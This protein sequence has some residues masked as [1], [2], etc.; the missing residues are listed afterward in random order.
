MVGNNSTGNGDQIIKL[1]INPVEWWF[2]LIFCSLQIFIGSI[3]NF[4]VIVT[5]FVSRQLRQRSEDRLILNLAITDFIC[6]T[7]ALPWHIYIYS[8]KQI[9]VNTTSFISNFSI[10]VLVVITGS[11]TIFCIAVDRFVAVV[12]PLRHPNI[13]NT[14]VMTVLS[15]GTAILVT[16]AIYLCFKF[17]QYGISY[18]VCVTS[19][20]LFLAMNATLYAI[21]FYHTLKQG[22]NILNKRRSVGAAKDEFSSHLLLKITLR[23]FLL[24]CLFYITYLPWAIYIIHFLFV[25][26]HD[27]ED[28]GDEMIWIRRVVFLNSF[29]NP[30]IY[31]LRTKRF[32]KEFHKKIWSR[33]FHRTAN[34]TNVPPLYH[35]TFL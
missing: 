2:Y 28:F 19:N 15:W 6:L 25:L 11:N 35:D 14:R 5:I 30:F 16:V 4:V 1:S 32:R 17:E 23:P 13:I 29:I 9:N 12:Y 26:G 33:C 21:I 34:E 18:I 7:I 27:W 3:A 22:R 20:L 31:G 8:H 10:V 24:M